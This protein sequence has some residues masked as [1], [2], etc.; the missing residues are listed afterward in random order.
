MFTKED[1]I[2]KKIL[3]VKTI[4]NHIYEILTLFKPLMERMIKMEEAKEF[5][6]N[7]TFDRA[8]SLFGEISDL[9]KKIENGSIRV[10]GEPLF[11]PEEVYNK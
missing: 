2:N 9:C 10:I 5:K 6:K 4:L 8:A 7:G 11:D 3:L 1:D